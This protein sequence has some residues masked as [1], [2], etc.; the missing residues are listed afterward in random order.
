MPLLRC[1]SSEG[2]IPFDRCNEEGLYES[3]L[4]DV[5]MDSTQFQGMTLKRY[6]YQ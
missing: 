4:W 6:S 3:E 5:E 1:I 2:D